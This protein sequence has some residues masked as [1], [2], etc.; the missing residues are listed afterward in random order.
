ME[1]LELRIEGMSCGHCVA[2]VRGA[3]EDLEGVTVED[4]RIGAAAVSFDPRRT[5]AAA[6]AGAVRAAGYE[7]VPASGP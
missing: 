3:L 1:T 4:V 6:I 2:A 7:A 5:D